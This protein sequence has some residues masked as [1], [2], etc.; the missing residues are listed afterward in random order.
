MNKFKQINRLIVIAI[1]LISFASCDDFLT[2]KEPEDK[3]VIEGYYNSK[4]RVEQAVIGVYVNFRRALL[5][6]RAWLMYGEVRAGELNIDVDYWGYVKNQQLTVDDDAVQQLTD[7]EYFYDVL[8]SANNT[9]DIIE[10][11]KGDVLEEY[12]YKLFKGEMLALKS[13]AYFYITRI[14][15]K[16][17]SAEQATSGKLWEQNEALDVALNLAVEA[18][19]LLP[20][21]LKNEDGIESAEL[22]R[23]RMSKYPITILLGEEYMWAKKY[24]E[25]YALLTAPEL[26]ENTDKVISFGFST[27]ED[28]RTNLPEKPL[29]GA[30]I[31][32]DKYNELYA[33]G[34]GAARFTLLEKE[35]IAKLNSF[36]GIKNLYGDTYFALLLAEAAWRADNLE[37]A[38]TTLKPYWDFFGQ[39]YSELKK[40]DFEAII[41]RERERILV[42]SGNRFFD[43]IRFGKVAEV[44]PQFSPEDVSEGAGYW[45]LSKKSLENKIDQNAYWSKQGS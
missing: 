40:E 18:H 30:S 23:V 2:I 12:D 20:W 7:W 10:K 45:P 39:D 42:G 29:E 14:W 9:L 26:Q 3:T 8:Y 27:G 6:N 13:M 28:Y 16:T 24:S 15:G 4:Q 5:E 35:G 41:L 33:G 22:T 43:L 19:K 17:I 32:I 44:I 21:R 11:V 25:A 1:A 38:K 31:S 34:G 37:L 36:P